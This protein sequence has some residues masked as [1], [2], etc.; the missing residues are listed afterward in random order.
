[1]TA[2]SE[3]AEQLQKSTEV[4]FLMHLFKIKIN[5]LIDKEICSHFYST[6]QTLNYLYIIAANEHKYLQL[7][8]AEKLNECDA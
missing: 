6:K 4:S 2:V 3:L 7:Q 1:M 5:T 8:L